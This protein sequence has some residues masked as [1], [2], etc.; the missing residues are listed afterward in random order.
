MLQA[1]N[2]NAGVD[3]DFFSKL[4]NFRL[5]SQRQQ[6]VVMLCRYQPLSGPLASCSCGSLL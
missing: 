3:I 5:G 6:P 2:N 1:T 4:E